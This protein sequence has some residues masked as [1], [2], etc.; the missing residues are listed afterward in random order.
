MMNLNMVVLAELCHRFGKKMVAR[1]HG[2]ILNVASTAAFQPGPAMAIYYATKAF[3]LS[4]SLAFAEE[5][6]GTGVTC[7]ALCPGPTESEFSQVAGVQESKLFRNAKLPTAREVAE[8]G[9]RH[10]QKGDAVAIHGVRNQVLA[11]LQRF[12]PRPLIMKVV[13]RLHQKI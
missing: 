5:L 11:S 3:V 9:Y 8:F 2:Q 13:K 1:G 6:K 12:V 7:T 4:F 10:S